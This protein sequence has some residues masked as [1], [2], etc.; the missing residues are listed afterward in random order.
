MRIAIYGGAFDPPHLSHVFT[1]TYLLTRADVDAVW[2]LPAADHAFG[3]RMTPYADRRAMLETLVERLGSPRL[4]I[5]DVETESTGRTF[6]TLSLLAERH[7][8][9]EFT[10]VIGADNL[11]ESHRWHRFDDLVARF[12]VIALGRPGHERALKDAAQKPWCRVGPTLAGVSSTRLRAALAGGDPGALRWLP[13]V[14]RDTADRLYSTRARRSDLPSVWIFGGG[15][16]GTSLAAAWRA[17]GVDVRGVWRRSVDAELPAEAPADVWIIAVSDPAIAEMARRL[18]GLPPPKVALHCAGRFDASILAPLTCARGS[19][20]PLQSIGDDPGA[21]RGAFCAVEGAPEAVALAQRLAKSFG[22]RPVTVPSGEKPAY[23]AAA[24][25]SA[26]FMTTLAAAGVALLEAIGVD[27]D[28]ARRMLTPLWQGT[29]NRNARLDA[30]EALTGPLARQ[31]IDAIEAHVQAL[32]RHA[33][34]F[35]AVYAE[36]AR[37][38]AAWLRWPESARAALD[39]ALA[40]VMKTTTAR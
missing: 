5:D 24:V 26:N 19:L 22:G 12:G 18:S 21:L 34:Q 32:A 36:L 15:R 8:D 25:V 37:T 1:L 14:L 17:A 29:L 4:R 6:D 23:H 28:T 2:I 20:H 39:D 7:P 35:S 30:A 27:A 11:T 3:K 33:P 16:L 10:L 13:D 31:D 38:T 9:H 40:G